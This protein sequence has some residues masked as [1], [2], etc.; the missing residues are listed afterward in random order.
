MLDQPALDL[1]WVVPLYRTGRQSESLALRCDATARALGLR[2]EILFVDDCCPER[3]Y[4]AVEALIPRLPVRLLRLPVNCGQDDALREGVRTARGAVVL[5]DG[6]LQDPP[7]A[8]ASLWP[9]FVEGY[10]AVF[11]NRH[12]RYEHSL[13]LATSRIYRRSMEW[14]GCLPRGAGLYVLMNARTAAALAATTTTPIY[15][16]AALAA[17]RGRFTSVEVLRASRP[18]GTS[19][20]SSWRR[21]RKGLAS[22]IQAFK[23][24]RLGVTL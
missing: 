22:A 4:R 10:D 6:D 7:E 21:L 9:R 14:I 11:A 12:G 1:T 23:S 13:R 18:E 8:L 3:G 5:L 2:H 15:L 16:L 19:S 24:R 17:T 20:Y